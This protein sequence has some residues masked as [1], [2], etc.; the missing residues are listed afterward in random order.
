MAPKRKSRT[1]KRT[2]TKKKS[3]GGAKPPTKRSSKTKKST[4][5]SRSRS[6]K[7]AP[8]KKVTKKTAAPKKANTGPYFKISAA[9]RKLKEGRWMANEDYNLFFYV[10]TQGSS[11]MKKASYWAAGFSQNLWRPIKTASSL[12][13]R[14][15]FYVRFLIGDDLRKIARYI[16]RGTGITIGYVNFKSTT[17]NYKSGPKQFYSVLQNPEILL[18]TPEK[19]RAPKEIMKDQALRA[20][21]QLDA[22]HKNQDSFHD[23]HHFGAGFGGFGGFAPAQP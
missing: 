11:G 1:K 10:K 22:L 2:V 18:I 4:A 23:H 5:R 3:R 19:R 20:R 17:A 21:A 8:K 12:R 15:R 7:K 6:T 9:Q 14:Y 13:S 16:Q